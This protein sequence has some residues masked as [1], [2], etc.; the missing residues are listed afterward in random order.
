MESATRSRSLRKEATENFL[1]SKTKDDRDEAILVTFGFSIKS[2]KS[3][4]VLR[5][6]A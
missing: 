4:E 1:L 6:W 3:P 5:L 2:Q